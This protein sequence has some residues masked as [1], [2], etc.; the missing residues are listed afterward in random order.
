MTFMN[1]V[2]AVVVFATGFAIGAY[3]QDRKVK[4]KYM[5]ESQ[6]FA[7][8]QID[9]MRKMYEERT[10]NF[11]AEVESKSREKGIEFAMQQLNLQKED[12][13]SIYDSSTRTYELISPDDFGNFDEF[14]TS[15]LTYFAD[16]VLAYDINGT[17]VE[18]PGRLIGPDALDSFGMYEP[19]IVHVRN[20]LYRRDYEITRSDAQYSDVYGS[21][22]EEDD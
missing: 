22:D 15:F 11:D 10:K 2:K 12:G 19:D 13:S 16:D 14:D 17:I 5:K 21:C 4:D 7:D 20:H 1:V 8:D 6:K 3:Y 9:D 18:D